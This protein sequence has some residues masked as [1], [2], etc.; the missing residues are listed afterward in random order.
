MRAAGYAAQPGTGPAGESC[1][2]CAHCCAKVRG[3]TYYKCELMMAAWSTC[4]ST[5]VLV[6]SPACERWTAGTPRMT[7]V[8]KLRGG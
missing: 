4:R 2:S 8:S 6:G 5:D 7:G 1:G 3:K